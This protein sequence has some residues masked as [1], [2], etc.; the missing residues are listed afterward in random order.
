[1]NP[2]RSNTIPDDMK[3]LAK[4]PAN[5]ARRFSAFNINRFKFQTLTREQGLKTQ[6]SGV[7]VTSSTSCI[8]SSVDGNLTEADLPYYGKLEDI[9]QLNYYGQFKV[10]HFKCKWAE[11]TRDKGLKKEAWDFT[12]VIFS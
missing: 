8:A 2:D 7:F 3:I 9:F 1:M 5:H 11:T 6:N 4:G 10:T 12:Y